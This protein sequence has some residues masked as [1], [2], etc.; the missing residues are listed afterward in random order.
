VWID[1]QTGYT[2]EF[3]VVDGS[4]VRVHP[5]FIYVFGRPG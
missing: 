3:F 5:E 2:E 1:K 4:N